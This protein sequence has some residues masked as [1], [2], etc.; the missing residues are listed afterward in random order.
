MKFEVEQDEFGRWCV[1]DVEH[2]PHRY[3]MAFR[4][5]TREEAEA[6]AERYNLIMS[7]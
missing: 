3:R 7:E 4:Y 5:T 1:V 2:K 6:R